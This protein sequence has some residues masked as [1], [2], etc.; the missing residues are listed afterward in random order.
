[1]GNFFSK[2][3]IIA[4]YLPWLLI[5]IAVLVIRMITLIVL[6]EEG[7]SLIDR[8]KNLVRGKV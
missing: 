8:L 7:V 4:D 3:G 5:G 2:R 1:M 6:Q